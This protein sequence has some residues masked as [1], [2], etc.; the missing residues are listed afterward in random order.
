MLRITKILLR[1]LGRVLRD[2]GT[3]SQAIAFSLFVTFFP[4]IVLVLGAVAASGQ[5]SGAV[6]ETLRDLHWLL[7]PGSRQVVMDFL[8]STHK[9]R[10]LLTLGSL[11]TVFAGTQ[12]MIGFLNAFRTI[13][14]DKGQYSFLLDQLRGVILLILTFAPFMA[15]SLLTVFGRQ[16]RGWMIQHFGLPGLF[17]AVWVLV[18]G[19]L[20]A[21]LATLTLA[22]LYRMGQPRGRSWNDFLPGAMVATVLWWVVNSAF[23]FYVRR[24]PYS[25]IYGGL[26]AAIGLA[27]WMNLSA[28]AVLFGAAFNA[29]REA[30]RRG[31]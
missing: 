5:L 6:Q 31:G 27:V 4:F 13:Y 8:A 24:V 29:E 21:V 15:V 16:F 25:V 12:A 22:L 3:H 30:L 18:Y 1:A 9:S 10:A 2:C 17:N 26:A 19:G 14:R 28:L 7:P 11:G 23:G 20:A